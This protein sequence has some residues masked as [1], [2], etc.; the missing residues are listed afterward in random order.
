MAQPLHGVKVVELAEGIAGPYAA[1]LFADF[2]AD[3]VKVEPTDGDAARWWGPFPE[4]GGPGREAPPPGS[5]TGGLT[6]PEDSATFLH[7][8]T[9][10][11]SIVA[12]DAATMERLISGADVVIE[13]GLP[14]S[15]DVTAHRARNPRLVVCSVTP[16]G[17][18]GPYAGYR[19]DEIILYGLGG[20]LSSTGL[21]RREPVKLGGD[22]GQ[23]Q[24]G[25]VARWQPWR[26]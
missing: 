3:V 2:G 5:A 17:Q 21:D 7:L 11:R 18:D 12:P 22:I 25:G 8:N 20:T 9:N 10:K 14:G 13:S 24:C 16:F 19:A 1:K 23:Y 15:F 6:P 26:R 4:G